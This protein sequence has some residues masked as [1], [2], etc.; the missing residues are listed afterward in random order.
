MA[1]PNLA[2]A[3]RAWTQPFTFD[4]ITKTIV[5]YQL[6]E[7]KSTISFKGVIQPMRAEQL[8][9]K[10]EGQRQWRWFTVHSTTDLQLVLDDEIVWKTKR[11]RVL[12]VSDYVDYGYFEYEI[13]EAFT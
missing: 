10:S 3:V 2:N 11:Y 13:A 8:E 7:T 12:A 4:R 1:L 5:N 6:V 9:I